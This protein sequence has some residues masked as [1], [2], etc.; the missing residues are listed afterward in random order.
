[1]TN[2]WGPRFFRSLTKDP[3]LSQ[4]PVIVISGLSRPELA[5]KKAVATLSKPFD[6]DEL[7]RLVRENIG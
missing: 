2:V 5:I 3:E 4:I 7:L 6:R 1:M